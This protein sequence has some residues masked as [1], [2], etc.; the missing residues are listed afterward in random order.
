MQVL[1]DYIVLWQRMQLVQLVPG[2]PD[3]FSWCFT[4]DGVYSAASRLMVPC[5]VPWRIYTAWGGTG[6]ADT[7]QHQPRFACSSGRSCTIGVV[8]DFRRSL[9]PPWLPTCIFCDQLPETMDHILL[10]CV[11][12]RETWQHIFL[13]RFHLQEVVQVQKEDFMSWWLRSGG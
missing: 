6:L 3:S 8:L 4:A 1:N 11:F 7:Y 12:A 10:G 13:V 9:L 2:T 5:H